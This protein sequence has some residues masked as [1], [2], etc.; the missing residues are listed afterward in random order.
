MNPT[1]ELGEIQPD[2]AHTWV[3]RATKKEDNTVETVCVTGTYVEARRS[4]FLMFGWKESENADIKIFDDAQTHKDIHIAGLYVALAPDSTRELTIKE[5]GMLETAADEQ[6]AREREEARRLTR[7]DVLTGRMEDELKK[8]L[9][10]E[11]VAVTVREL[12]DELIPT[13][14][15]EYA[16]GEMLDL[17][18]NESTPSRFDF[19]IRIIAACPECQEPVMSGKVDTVK[20]LYREV[21]RMGERFGH[22]CDPERLEELEAERLRAQ[23][24]FK[25]VVEENTD[26]S[27]RVRLVDPETGVYVLGQEYVI[28][29]SEDA[30]PISEHG[31]AMIADL[32]ARSLNFHEWQ[33]VEK[34]IA[35]V[36]EPVAS[37]LR[38]KR[39]AYVA[40]KVTRD[41]LVALRLFLAHLRNQETP[42]D[43]VSWGLE[44]R[45]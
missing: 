25:W 26:R 5:R 2:Q 28:V 12:R 16:P 27:K 18:V 30:A 39:W 13:A 35:A 7:I 23:S 37:L 11:G 20:A 43:A 15:I 8:V 29:A 21:E 31:V 14:R 32:V 4:A 42:A 40:P 9:G 36:V 24:R 1:P 19:A 41:E 3:A 10:I 34:A 17:I 6:E 33:S 45:P 22:V 44:A 38:D